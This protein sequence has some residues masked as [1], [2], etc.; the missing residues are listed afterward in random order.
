MELK[1]NREQGRMERLAFI[2]RYS[3]W[4][5]SVPNAVWSR[6]QAS[7]INSFLTSSKGFQL[8]RREYLMMKD[9]S[10]TAF[11]RHNQP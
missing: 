11:L 7:L 1:F 2:K 6:Q 5:K 3:E 9:R 10:K 8:G 4:V